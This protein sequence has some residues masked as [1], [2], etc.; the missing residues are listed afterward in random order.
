[1][2]LFLHR[3]ERNLGKVGCTILGSIVGGFAAS[4]SILSWISWGNS[5]QQQLAH[6]DPTRAD[7]VDILLTIAT[8]FLGALGLAVTVGALVIGVVALKTLREIKEEASSEAKNAAAGKINETMA[9][10]LDPKVAAKVKEALPESLKSALLDEETGH[11]IMIK[12][13]RT[14]ELDDVVGRVMARI[15][16]GGPVMD[17]SDVVEGGDQD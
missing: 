5:T 2:F 14:G 1:M 17:P 15:N 11:R 10:E 9:A 16:F 4:V 7:F 6:I 8:L 3:E 12:L 13:A